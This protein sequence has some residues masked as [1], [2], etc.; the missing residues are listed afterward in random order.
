[1]STEQ[2]SSDSI[3]AAG[4]DPDKI[5]TNHPSIARLIDRDHPNGQAVILRDLQRRIGEANAAK[6]FHERGVKLRAEVEHLRAI[7]DG[8][9]V[10]VQEDL[11]EAEQTLR[12]YETARMALIMTEASEAIDET[13]AGRAADETYYSGGIGYSVDGDIDEGEATDANGNPRKPEGVPSEIADVVIR[14]FDFAHEAGFD[15]ADIIF[16]KLAYNATR[17]HKHGRKF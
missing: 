12:E 11:E 3:S 15:L 9:S 2:I 5:R 10:T 14:S 1:M 7:A 4:V 6:G 16:E 8:G 13:R 17:A